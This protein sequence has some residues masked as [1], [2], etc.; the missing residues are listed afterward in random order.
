MSTVEIDTL[1]RSI[2]NHISRKFGIV[3]TC[4]IYTVDTQNESLA[5]L[6]FVRQ[7]QEAG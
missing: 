5:A 4:G 1:T 3:L 2:S 7:G 6:F